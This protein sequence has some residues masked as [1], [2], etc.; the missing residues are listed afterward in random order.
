MNL[1]I[2]LR[3]Q[4]LPRRSWDHFCNLA[5]ATLPLA[6]PL[7]LLRHPCTLRGSRRVLLSI[8]SFKIPRERLC[9][10]ASRWSDHLMILAPLL[11]N[12]CAS[13]YQ[14]TCTTS[15]FSPICNKNPTCQL[16]V[17]RQA[18][19]KTYQ[20]ICDRAHSIDHIHLSSFHRPH[21]PHLQGL[22]Q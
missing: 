11:S 12:T 8:S 15:R 4:M 18:F 2:V 13:G 5:N 7:N 1:D 16:Y 19:N 9:H 14:Q 3:N 6:A 21:I 20:E 10:S 17:V 22:L